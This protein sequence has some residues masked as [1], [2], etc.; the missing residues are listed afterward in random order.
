MKL[1]L[2]PI[3]FSILL[4]SGCHQTTPETHSKLIPNTINNRFKSYMDGMILG[5]S[6]TIQKYLYKG[7]GSYFQEHT[8]FEFDINS[9]IRDSIVKPAQQAQISF[10]QQGLTLF[11]NVLPS[12]RNTT[13]KETEFYLLSYELKVTDTMDQ[14]T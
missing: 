11:Y 6:D 13:I 9:Y 5:H 10:R 8:A 12:I 7:V 1:K 4:F 3:V 14:I 2:S